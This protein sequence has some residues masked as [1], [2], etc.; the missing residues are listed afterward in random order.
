MFFPE[1]KRK[2]TT[3]D[4]CITKEDGRYGGFQFQKV[5]RGLFVEGNSLLFARGRRGRKP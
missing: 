3:Y 5:Q 2:K 4:V 1:K